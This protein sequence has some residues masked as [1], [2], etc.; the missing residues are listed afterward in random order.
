[1]MASLSSESL[2]EVKKSLP[3]KFHPPR[4]FKFPKRKF[5]KKGEA[6]WLF[7]V[8]GVQTPTILGFTMMLAAIQIYLIIEVILITS[9][10]CTA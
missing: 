8:D 4:S 5:G 3:I 9:N 10:A 2:R 7:R 6:M 1:M